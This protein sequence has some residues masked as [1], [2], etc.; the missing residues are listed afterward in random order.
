M[1]VAA[2]FL[3]L[4][5][6]IV[7]GFFGRWIGDRGAQLVTCLAMLA[8]AAAGVVLFVEVALNGGESVTFLFTFIDAGKLQVDWALKFDTLSAVMVAMVTVVSAMIHMFSVF[9]IS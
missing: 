7:A 3:P 2:V 8:S 1:S 9:L 4:L 5:G 6:A